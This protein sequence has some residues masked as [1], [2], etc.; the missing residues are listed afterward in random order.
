MENKEKVT[1]SNQIINIFEDLLKTKCQSKNQVQCPG[2]TVLD[3]TERSELYT[4]IYSVLNNERI[5]ENVNA[6]F[7]V[8]IPN[9]Y[10]MVES[11]GTEHDYPDVRICFSEDGKLFSDS[12][13]IAAVE[14][15]TCAKEIRTI[16]Y[17]ANNDEPNNIIRY[18]DGWNLI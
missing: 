9:G 10:F 2:A 8:K 5:T 7:K 4:K 3:D 16:T 1:L 15:D 17:Q 6:V 11:A 18:K 13:L 12:N 14:F